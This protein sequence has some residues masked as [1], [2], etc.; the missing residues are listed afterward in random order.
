MTIGITGGIG[1]GKSYI[2]RWLSERYA[3]PLYDCDRE[4]RRLMLT[5]ALRRRLTAL[6]GAEAYL[7]DGQL[8]K[9]FVAQYLFADDAHAAAVNAIVHPAVRRDVRRWA[10]RQAGPS[11]VES[12]I[13]VEAGLLDVVDKLIVVEAPLELRIQR[14]ISRDGTT[15]HQVRQRIARQTTDDQRR[16]FADCVVVNDGSDFTA[17]LR[18]FID[19][20]LAQSKQNA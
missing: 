1:S 9:P 10:Q 14:V 11:L 4:A 16:R 20:L 8:N 3:M 12:A 19:S 7:P 5:P 2:A 6:I 17:E 15:G 18:F 13:L